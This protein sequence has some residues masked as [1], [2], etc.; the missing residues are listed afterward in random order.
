MTNKKNI[1]EKQQIPAWTCPKCG[2]THPITVRDCCRNSG[3]GDEW[4]WPSNPYTPTLPASPWTSGSPYDPEY[5]P[6]KKIRWMR[7]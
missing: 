7:E 4:V 1:P 6:L 2:T 3:F 5:M